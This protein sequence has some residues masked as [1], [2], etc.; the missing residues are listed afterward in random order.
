MLTKLKMVSE[1]A[2]RLSNNLEYFSKLT[3]RTLSAFH[4]VDK[5]DNIFD[6][7]EGL[8]RI[9]NKT[10]IKKLVKVEE[11]ENKL[12][13]KTYSDGSQETVEEKD[14]ETPCFYDYNE[15][16]YSIIKEALLTQASP[17]TNMKLNKF[18]ENARKAIERPS[19]IIFFM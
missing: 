17:I 13:I 15:L 1:T 19:E 2:K 5:E 18:N 14:I 3:Q 4:V 8:K 7:I 16:D 9:I 11:L 6:E 10:I 12:F